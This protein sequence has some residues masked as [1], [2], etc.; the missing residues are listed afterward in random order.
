MLVKYI[1]DFLGL[2]VKPNW[3][4]CK[5]TDTEPID[6]MG[7]VFRKSRTTIRTKIFL[8]TRRYFLKAIKLLKKGL[9]IPEKL[10]YQCISGYGWY[11][12]TDSY[13]IRQKLHIDEIHLKCCKTISY[14]SKLR[15]QIK[16]GGLNAN[17]LQGQT[18]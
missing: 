2:D 6:M 11:K 8:K 10:A 13:R 14:Y 7:F 12:N 1:K 5:L 18:A 16:K 4:V 3:K 17:I 9:S 15:N